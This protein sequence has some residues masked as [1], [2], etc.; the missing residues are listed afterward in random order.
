VITTAVFTKLQSR[1]DEIAD[2][3][4]EELDPAVE[5]AAQRLAQ[6]AKQTTPPANDSGRLKESIRVIKYDTCRYNVV[7]DA[8]AP[9]RPHLPYGIFLEYGT[10]S[11][12]RGGGGIAATHF[13]A[14]AAEANLQEFEQMI[15][16]KLKQL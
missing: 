13:M 5:E 16:D 14:R 6:G 12:G 2:Q 10:E 9:S 11:G 3:L 15:N 7:A 4:A 1:L 8:K